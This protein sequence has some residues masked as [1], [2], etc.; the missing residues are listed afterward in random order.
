MKQKGKKKETLWKVM[1]QLFK[2]YA[3]ISVLAF[4]HWCLPVYIKRKNYT[5]WGKIFAH[6]FKFLCCAHSDIHFKCFSELDCWYSMNQKSWERSKPRCSTSGTEKSQILS[7]H[8]NDVA[9]YPILISYVFKGT[10]DWRKES[11]LGF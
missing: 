11:V 8:L 7:G 1:F 6:V 3:K 2:D 10:K 5:G 4:D 9:I